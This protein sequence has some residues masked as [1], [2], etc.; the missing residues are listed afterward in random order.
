MMVWPSALFEE[1]GLGKRYFS[2]R[3]VAGVREFEAD[4]KPDLFSFTSDALRSLVAEHCNDERS[5]GYESGNDSGD[6]R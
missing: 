1:D 6:S 4:C 2:G 5:D 3:G